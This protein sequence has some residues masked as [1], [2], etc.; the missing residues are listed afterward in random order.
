MKSH[1][2]TPLGSLS[3]LHCLTDWTQLPQLTTDLIINP[4]GPLHTLSQTPSKGLNPSLPMWF[5]LFHLTCYVT[6]FLKANLFL[7]G[8]T[9]PT[10]LT[11][12]FGWNSCN[13]TPGL[14]TLYHSLVIP[15]CTNFLTIR[16][17]IC[18]RSTT[19]FGMHLSLLYWG[20]YYETQWQVFK[21]P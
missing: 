17:G 6:I 4:T 5:P 9:L 16:S 3:I 15:T 7:L 21:I 19:E 10:V 12:N 18:L 14:F 20:F 11:Q 1:I 8:H 2:M 13:F